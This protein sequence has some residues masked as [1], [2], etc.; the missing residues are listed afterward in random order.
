MLYLKR[1]FYNSPFHRD[2]MLLILNFPLIHKD[3]LQN[4]TKS[5][6]YTQHAEIIFLIMK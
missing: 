1:A 6:K 4:V 3:C 5:Y 2:V